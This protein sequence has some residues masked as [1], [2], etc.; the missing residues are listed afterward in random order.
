LDVAAEEMT[1]RM[2]MHSADIRRE[3]ANRLENVHGV[4]IIRRVDL[5]D[6]TL[7]RFDPET[8]RLEFSA[9]LSAGQRTM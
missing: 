3:I 2:R 7:H 9:A 8:R 5:G 6:Y 1:V 4:S